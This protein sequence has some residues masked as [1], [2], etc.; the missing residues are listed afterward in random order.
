MD[1]SD[2]KQ[3]PHPKQAYEITVTIRDAPGPFDSVKGEMLFR[4]ANSDCVPQDPVSGARKVPISD[5][6]APLS[7][8][9]TGIFS[10]TVYLDLLQDSNYFGLGTCRWRLEDFLATFDAF[11]VSF[12]GNILEDQIR[13]EVSTTQYIAKK[14]FRRS[15]IPDMSVGAVP[16]SDYIRANREKFFSITLTAKERH[17][18]RRME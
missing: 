10:G 8:T 1:D 2:I 15:D 4:V 5:V 16:M 11:D 3:N 13:A 14:L 6:A 9:G 17:D 12:G 7:Q 18:G